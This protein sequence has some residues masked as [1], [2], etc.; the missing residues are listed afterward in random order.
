MSDLSKTISGLSP[1]RRR[2]LERVLSQRGV[3]LSRSVIL[4]QWRDRAGAPLSFAQQRLW[5]LDRWSPG[6]ALYSVVSAFI[7]TG[8]LDSVVLGSALGEVVRRHEA[9]RTCFV[10]IDGEPLQR[11]SPARPWQLPN[12]DLR[13]LAPGER[14]AE[15]R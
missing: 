15:V 6:A 14:Q 12:V 1:E 3:D 4:P 11:V 8:P 2:L 13:R 7:L 5:F 10:A 9:L